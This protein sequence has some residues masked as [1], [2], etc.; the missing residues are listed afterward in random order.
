MGNIGAIAFARQDDRAGTRDRPLGGGGTLSSIFQR[1]PVLPF[2]G[3][4]MGRGHGGGPLAEPAVQHHRGQSQALCHGGTGPV[5]PEKRHALSANGE[6]RGD[7]L[8]EKVPGKNKVQSGGRL[9]GLI[10]SVLERQLLHG[11]LRLLPTGLAE[12]IVLVDQIKGG[13]Q[14]SLALF[15]AHHVGVAGDGGRG[16]KGNRLLSQLFCRHVLQHSFLYQAGHSL[17]SFPQNMKVDF[18]RGCAGQKR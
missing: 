18:G 5:K 1:G 4:E 12:G 13:A 9:L 11:A 10:Q 6:G 15:F 16:G 2:G 8:I 17:N 14:R 3:A 7:T